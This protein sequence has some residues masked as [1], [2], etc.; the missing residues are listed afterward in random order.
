MR[1]LLCLAAGTFLALVT[2]GVLRAQT[3]DEIKQA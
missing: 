3:L 2:T 1:R